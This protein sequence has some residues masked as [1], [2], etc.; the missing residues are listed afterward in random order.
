MKNIFITFLSFV[1]TFELLSILSLSFPNKIIKP[2]TI[3]TSFNSDLNTKSVYLVGD[4]FAGHGY[5]K[6]FKE[7]FNAK[8][9]NFYDLSE[10]GTELDTHRIILD[11]LN[12]IK[13]ELIIYFY[14]I[15]DIVAIDEPI[16]NH[17]KN[18]QTENKGSFLNYLRKKNHTIFLIKQLFHHV[19]LATTGKPTPGSNSYNIPKENVNH[20]EELQKIFN[21]IKSKELIIVVN[22]SFLYGNNPKNWVHYDMFNKMK[23]NNNILLL[24]TVDIVDGPQFSISWRNGHPND[25][26]IDLISKK[27]IKDYSEKFLMK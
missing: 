11:S 1:L 13:P 3:E 6:I 8:S 22:S 15:A 9:M 12:Q 20:K 7:Y 26:A 19:F 21:S 5:P 16:L 27:I 25:K 24:Q 14:N 4:S 23:L 2:K 18:K 10:A 17:Q